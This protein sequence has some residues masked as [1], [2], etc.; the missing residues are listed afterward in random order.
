MHESKVCFSAEKAWSKITEDEIQ[1]LL[2]VCTEYKAE[3]KYSGIDWESVRNKYEKIQEKL[4]QQYS[5]SS[6]E[7][8]N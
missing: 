1:L 6:T 7:K 5:K 2:E 8:F 3:H 4:I